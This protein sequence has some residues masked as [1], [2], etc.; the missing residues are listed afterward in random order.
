MQ[1]GVDVLIATPGR[2]TDL[3]RDNRIDLSETRWLVLD[4]ADRMLDMGFINDV[5][6]IAKGTHRDRQTALFSA[7][8]P[9]EVATLA[10]SLLRNPIRVEVAPQ[11]TTA[12]EI[13]QVVHMIPTKQKKQ[14]LSAMLK[15]ATLS[16]VIVFTRTKHGADAVTRVLE[17]DGYDVAA[18]HGNKSQ[19]ARQR[20]L[21]GFKDG[22]VRVLVATDIA[23]R[24]IDVVGI[25]HVINFDLPDEP[26]SYVH[27]IG[28]TG[29]NGASGNA[30]TLYDP[31]EEASKFKAV[32]RVTR[33]RLPLADS[34][35]DLSTLPARVA[36]NDQRP[37][38]R[39]GGNGA[40]GKKP[41]RGQA[42]GKPREPREPRGE[43]VWSNDGGAPAQ[44]RPFRRAKRK[45]FGAKAA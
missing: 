29:R 28:R 17:K 19:N 3:V 40:P 26:E 42:P 24:G 6:R 1:G 23:A 8:M 25:S 43:K 34:P 44:K 27:R 12:A 5:K 4:E 36:S 10:E 38:R 41:H 22:S 20:A 9:K 2:L 11:G 31:A 33:M 45:S 7:T 39:E 14:V 18:I 21:N 37:A 15:D 30:I 16:S 13:K 32:E 35:I